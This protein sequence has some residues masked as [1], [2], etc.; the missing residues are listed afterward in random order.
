MIAGA[1]L[2]GIIASSKTVIGA[3]GGIHGFIMEY[4]TALKTAMELSIVL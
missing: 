3:A 1:E 4:K 2:I